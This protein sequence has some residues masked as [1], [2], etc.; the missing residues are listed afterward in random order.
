MIAFLFQIKKKRRA[1]SLN[2]PQKLTHF[3]LNECQKFCNHAIG[4]RDSILIVAPTKKNPTRQEEEKRRYLKYL[5]PCR[6]IRSSIKSK[7]M[8]SQSI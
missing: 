4:D 8:L 7:H 1:L 3:V 5:V 2:C 6:T